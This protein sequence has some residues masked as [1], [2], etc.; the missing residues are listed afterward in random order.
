MQRERAI[1]E[2]RARGL[3]AVRKTIRKGVD[4]VYAMPYINCMENAMNHK[5]IEA[6]RDAVYS[7][8]KP[9][10]SKTVRVKCEEA[11]GID[12]TVLHVPPQLMAL[13]RVRGVKVGR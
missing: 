8:P 1:E 9:P 12:G 11:Q 4:T 2:A 10:T 6:M 3:D 13:A 5:Q 7:A